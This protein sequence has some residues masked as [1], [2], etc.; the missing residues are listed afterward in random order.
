MKIAVYAVYKL[1]YFLFNVD[2]LYQNK[3]KPSSLERLRNII[4]V[5]LILL[6]ICISCPKML[7]H[8][9]LTQLDQSWYS[10]LLVYLQTPNTS[11]IQ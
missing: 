5:C 10:I 9:A 4:Q 6:S 3:I 7:K 1:E 11:V 2:K 8:V